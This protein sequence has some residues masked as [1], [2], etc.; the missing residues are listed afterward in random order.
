MDNITHSLA[1]LLLAESAVRL[2]ARA[3]HAEP[4]PRFRAVA[5]VASL[6]AA[7]LPDG[8]LLYTGIGASRLQYMLQHRGYTHTV[9]LALVGGLLVW[10]VAMLVWRWQTR[11]FPEAS[12]A[13]WLLGLL[14]VS[15][16]S[17]LVL[18][19][20]NSYGVHPFWP[21]DNRWRYGDAVFIIEPWLWV[22]S[23]PTLVA[24]T[25]RRWAR[26]AL[27]LVLLAGLVLA[28]RVSFVS[29]GAA[30]ALS[31]GA[32][33]FVALAY[34]L[35]PPA[36]A[37]AAVLGWVGVT[38]T[39][40]LGAARARSA[41]LDALRQI[42]SRMEILDVVVSPLPANAICMSVITV[43]R[44]GE[45]YRA[46]TARVSATPSLV[47]AAHCGSRDVSGS[48]IGL[49]PRQSTPAVQWE[50]EWTGRHAELAALVRESCT[51]LAA[52]R[53]I[54]VPIWR[55]ASDSAV[56]LGDL[57]YGGASGNGFANVIA[58]AGETECPRRVPPWTPPREDVTGAMG[59]GASP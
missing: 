36:R 27:S 49:S 18:D 23:I 43:E 30:A 41:M 51:A 29:K 4:S 5:A 50:G 34:P 12:D 47:D 2:R 28:W 1:G 53:F 31:I 57:R 21:F 17:H 38:L 16:L 11:R 48:G 46:S 56:R 32:A 20:T 33:F 6:I 39:M 58:R 25:T 40:A 9:V 24:A 35:R 37:V 13:R 52:M 42:D 8:D 45:I 44:S 19:W 55:S 59:L 26:V 3:E 7:N 54:R 15:T 10:C 22:V 14:V